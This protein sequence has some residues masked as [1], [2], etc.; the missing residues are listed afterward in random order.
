[1]GQ[2]KTNGNVLDRSVGMD[3]LGHKACSMMYISASITS[4][5]LKNA[6]L[7]TVLKI[8]QSAGVTMEVRQHL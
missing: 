3:E 1:M 7:K 6:Y 2:K 8:T 4:T 5:L